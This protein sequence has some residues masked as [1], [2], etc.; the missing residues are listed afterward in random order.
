[1]ANRGAGIILI[2]LICASLLA[3][4]H[5]VSIDS[6]VVGAGQPWQWTV[7][8][9]GTSDEIAHIKCVEYVLDPSFPESS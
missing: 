8:L 1:M 4:D 5:N 2:L 7:F 9:K 3:A 6:L